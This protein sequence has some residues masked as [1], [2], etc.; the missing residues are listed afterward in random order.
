MSKKTISD[1]NQ[2]SYNIRSIQPTSNVG[3]SSQPT[4]GQGNNSGNNPPSGGTKK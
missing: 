4:T 1:S 3:G 2:P